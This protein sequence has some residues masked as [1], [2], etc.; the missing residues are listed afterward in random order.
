MIFTKVRVFIG[1]AALVLIGVCAN[2]SV[3][4]DKNSVQN[5]PA[6]IAVEKGLKWLVTVQGR[7]GGW[8]QD[9]GETS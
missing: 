9:G 7:D 4:A 2:T 6:S 3:F 8:G 1:A 5:D